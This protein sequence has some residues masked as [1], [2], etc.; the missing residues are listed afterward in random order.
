MLIQG[1]AE[2]RWDQIYHNSLLNEHVRTPTQLYK[3]H[4]FLFAKH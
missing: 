3:T 4:L 2:H 1:T